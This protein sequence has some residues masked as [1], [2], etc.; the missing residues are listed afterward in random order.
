[1]LNV[2]EQC[3]K[4]QNECNDMAITMGTYGRTLEQAC[5]M[6]QLCLLCVRIH[7]FKKETVKM[8]PHDTYNFDMQAHTHTL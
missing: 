7:L 6:L 5:N 4:V 1:M 3:P 8:N 2:P